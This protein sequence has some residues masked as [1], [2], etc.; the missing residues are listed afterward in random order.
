MHYIFFLIVY[1]LWRSTCFNNRYIKSIMS[2]N[3]TSIKKTL[4]NH[5]VDL[6][7]HVKLISKNL[8]NENHICICKIVQLYE[9]CVIHVIK[10]VNKITYSFHILKIITDKVNVVFQRQSRIHFITFNQLQKRMI[11][12]IKCMSSKVYFFLKGITKRH[13]RK[14]ALKKASIHKTG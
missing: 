10:L 6:N 2:H 8:E 12:K 7:I 5:L 1:G 13:L 3:G 11:S 4:L 9:N 14:K